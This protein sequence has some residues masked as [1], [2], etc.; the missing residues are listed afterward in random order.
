MNGYCVREGE[1]C[2]GRGE[3]GCVRWED[4]VCREKDSN[5]EVGV[6]IVTVVGMGRHP[7][8]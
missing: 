6:V 5:M 4:T 1:G 3:G 7:Q 8:E 2:K